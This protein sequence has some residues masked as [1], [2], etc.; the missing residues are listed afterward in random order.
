[1]N[2]QPEFSPLTLCISSIF[3]LLLIFVRDRS[4]AVDP[5]AS[6]LFTLLRFHTGTCS[7]NCNVL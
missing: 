6:V 1:M 4:K 2:E 3:N 5:A 7:V